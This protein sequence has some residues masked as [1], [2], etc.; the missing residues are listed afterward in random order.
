MQLE[1]LRVSTLKLARTNKV[2]LI[3]KKYWSTATT[4][5]VYQ[6]NGQPPLLLLAIRT[7][8]SCD[9]HFCL[10]E[11]WSATSVYQ[12]TGQPLLPFLSNRIPVSCYC[13]FCL[14]RILVSH[15]CH[16]C[17]PEYWSATTAISVYPNTS[18]LLL[19]LLSY[20]N[21][22][23]P[24]MPPLSTKISSYKPVVLY[25]SHQIFQATFLNEINILYYTCK[26]RGTLFYLSNTVIF[27]QLII[28]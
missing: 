25:S 9:C 19:P 13:H 15:Y 23:Q 27:C 28:Y 11:N 16:C 1:A 7:L 2:N 3:F 4:T 17:L 6:N 21:T 26:T 22:G 14:I 20:Q 12:S 10:P 5:S 24:L 18:Q 8:V